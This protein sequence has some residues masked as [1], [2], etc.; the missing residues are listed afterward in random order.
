MH[1]PDGHVPV[2]TPAAAIRSAVPTV[3]AAVTVPVTTKSTMKV[4]GSRGN[5]HSARISTA[6]VSR[7]HQA[8]QRNPSNHRSQHQEPFHDLFLH[9]DLFSL[10]FGHPCDPD[11]VKKK[12]GVCQ[13]LKATDLIFRKALFQN[14]LQHKGRNQTHGTATIKVKSQTQHAPS[15][16]IDPRFQSATAAIHPVVGSRAANRIASHGFEAA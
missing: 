6:G 11:G 1:V 13:F 14:D 15:K 8:C 10:A 4:H 12:Q 3:S 9:F 2:T 7:T 5:D 16:R